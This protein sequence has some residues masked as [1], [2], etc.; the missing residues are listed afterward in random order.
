MAVSSTNP[1]RESMCKLRRLFYDPSPETAPQS[2]VNDAVASFLRL[3]NSAPR[4]RH[5]TCSALIVHMNLC[6]KLR[7]NFELRALQLVRSTSPDQ[8]HAGVCSAILTT[9]MVLSRILLRGI[10]HV[11]C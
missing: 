6:T 4:H 2:M 10:S 8:T 7:E 1:P 5:D 3:C 9:Q 11:E